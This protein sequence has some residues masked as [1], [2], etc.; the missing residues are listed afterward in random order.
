MVFL[1]IDP[2]TFPHRRCAAALIAR[3][4]PFRHHSQGKQLLFKHLQV[5]RT[6]RHAV[7][8]AIL[9]NVVTEFTEYKCQS[10]SCSAVPLGC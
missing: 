4:A 10:V 1:M 5:S 9:P 8:T 2:Q 7:S 6:F 3:F